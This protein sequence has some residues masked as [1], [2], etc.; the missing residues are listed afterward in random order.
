MTT[1]AVKWREPDGQTFVGRL[2]LGPR[3]LR[4]DGRRPGAEGPAVKRQFGYEE[5]RGL[6]IGSRGPDRLDGRPAL[7]VERADGSYL[8]ADAGMGAPIVQELV[9]RL[10]DL[11]LTAPRKAT[12]VVPLKVGVIDRVR[13]L[14]SQG[15]PFDP[16]ETPLTRHELLLT[17]QEAIFVFE[18]ETE[19]G[20]RMLLS[21]LDIWAAAA[22][23]GELVAGPPRL[24]DIAYAWE[25][26]EPSSRSLAGAG[27]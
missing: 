4:L 14:V 5:L 19:D 12:V 27:R 6:R 1:Y 24:A 3:T 7:V 18:A 23:W 26:P 15:P 16:S 17:P 11:R 2:A 13:E 21:Q 25:R 8:V 9:E 20:L 10:A 22:A